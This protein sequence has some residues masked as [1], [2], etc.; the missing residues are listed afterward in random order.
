MQERDV[1]EQR[2]QEGPVADHL[3]RDEDHEGA[4][5]VALD[6]RGRAAEERHEPARAGLVVMAQPT[7]ASCERISEN[8]T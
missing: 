1:F 7:I 8:G 4:P 2:V 6:V 3:A 5:P